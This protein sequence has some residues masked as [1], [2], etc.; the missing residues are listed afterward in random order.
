M[1][2]RARGGEGGPEA[3][4]SAFNSAGG[5]G[6]EWKPDPQLSGGQGGPSPALLPACTSKGE[7]EPLNTPLLS[8]A[9][10]PGPAPLGP[11]LAERGP[12][13][14]ASHPCCAAG[15]RSVPLFLTRSPKLREVR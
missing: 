10:S 12:R 2:K 1:G 8:Q 7:R 5:R 13:P 3:A 4:L 15:A 14:A 11:A 6:P 9:P